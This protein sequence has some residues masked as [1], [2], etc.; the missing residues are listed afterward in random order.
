MY[1]ARERLHQVTPLKRFHCSEMDWESSCLVPSN[2]S[3]SSMAGNV[4]SFTCPNSET[5]PLHSSGDVSSVQSFVIAD[6]SV[7]TAWAEQ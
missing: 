4:V 5:Q 2:C 7:F 6:N 1:R 3:S